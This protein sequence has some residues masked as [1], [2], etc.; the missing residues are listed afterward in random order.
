MNN[1]Q[2]AGKQ[3]EFRP[4]P[5]D[6]N[7][8]ES[9][10]EVTSD[11]R[12]YSHYMKTF[13]KPFASTGGYLRVKLNYGSQ[14]KKVMAHRLVAMAFIPNPENKPVVNHKNCIRTDNRV[15]NLE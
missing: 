2:S 8:F 9:N 13:L 4:M 11:G 1:R 5:L 10:Y 12:V 7:G 14:N 3:P 6:L 15:E